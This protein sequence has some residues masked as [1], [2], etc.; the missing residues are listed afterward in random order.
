MSCGAD[1]KYANQVCYEICYAGKCYFVSDKDGRVKLFI[2]LVQERENRIDDLEILKDGR[3]PRILKTTGDC[4]KAGGSGVLVV[5][6]YVAV[7]DP[8]PA[9]KG[10]ATILTAVGAGIVCGGTIWEAI[11][12]ESEKKPIIN[13]IHSATMTAIDIFFDIGKYPSE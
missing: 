9:S 4:I 12:R 7:A 5:T 8:E 11:S 10:I 2:S 3:W 1:S 6:F 13:D